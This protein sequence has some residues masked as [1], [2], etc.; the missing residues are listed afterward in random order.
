[1]VTAKM[2][3]ENKNG[4]GIEIVV[5]GIDGSC[6]FPDENLTLIIKEFKIVSQKIIGDPDFEIECG[7]CGDKQ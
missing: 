4:S 2:F 5:K 6:M 1:M 7:G 3:I